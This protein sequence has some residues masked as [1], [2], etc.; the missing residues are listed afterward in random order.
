MNHEFTHKKTGWKVV[1]KEL[2][3]KQL[4][5]YMAAWRRLRPAVASTPED[6]GA[7]LRAA[8]SSGILIETN[9][10]LK[11]E[12]VDGL[13]PGLVR[14]MADRIDQVYEEATSVPPE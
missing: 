13:S 10:P 12:D 9:P 14:W 2:T 11:P 3:Q 8:L 1:V 6:D 7:V 5:D 4:E